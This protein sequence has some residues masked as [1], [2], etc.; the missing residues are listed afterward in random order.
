VT[1]AVTRDTIVTYTWTI[2]LK[3]KRLKKIKKK[4]KKL[5]KPGADCGIYCSKT[6]T[7]YTP[8]VKRTKLTII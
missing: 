4:L 5:K 2:F 8:L 3:L 1:L 6:L 7:I